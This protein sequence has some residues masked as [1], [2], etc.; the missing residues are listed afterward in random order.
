MWHRRGFFW[1]GI[2]AAYRHPVIPAHI[3]FIS[4]KKKKKISPRQIHSISH[5]RLQTP[6]SFPT[7]TQHPQ[8][9]QSSVGKRPV[10]IDHQHR[11]L[12]V[13]PARPGLAINE[14]GSLVA[15][16]SRMKQPLIQI[17]N[18]CYDLSQISGLRV[19]AWTPTSRGSLSSKQ[20][21]VPHERTFTVLV[22]NNFILG[23]SQTKYIFY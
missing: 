9:G 7:T 19:L 5:P 6:C 18:R 1:A 8:S 23:N 20:L 16:I 12:V 15:T 10:W 17:T 14:V 22:A 2:H 13:G 21:Q 3:N 4:Q 11:P